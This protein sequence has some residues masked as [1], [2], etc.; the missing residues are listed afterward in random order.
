MAPDADQLDDLRRSARLLRDTFL[1]PRFDDERYLRWF[2]RE[3]PNGPALEENVDDGGTRMGHLAGIPQV[4]H[5]QG[6]ELPV[7]FPLDL[8]VAPAARGKGLMSALNHRCLRAATDGLDI[9]AFVSVPNDSSTPGY[10]GRLQFRLVRP[11][12]VVVCLPWNVGGW[13]VRSIEV[14]RAYLHSGDFDDLVASLDFAPGLDWSQ[15]WSPELLRWRLAAPGADYR[16][17]VTD[18]LVGVSCRTRAFGVPFAVILKIFPRVAA[19]RRR[20]GAIVTAACRAHRAPVAVYAGFNARADVRG[21]PV[22]NRLKP[23]P[24][25]LV[26][27]SLDSSVVRQEDFRF[28]TFEFLDFDAY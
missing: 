15:K 5:R 2:Y 1:L 21:I 20:T 27:R 25:N 28:G 7:V 8:A 4:Y 10:T 9:V 11:L 14:T 6:Q 3:N 19:G 26:F 18:D 23:A 22:P 24:L 13:T 12:P 16:L 17:H